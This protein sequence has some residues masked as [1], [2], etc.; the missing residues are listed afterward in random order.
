MNY[1][2]QGIPFK[3]LLNIFNFGRYG[4]IDPFGEVKEYTYQ[5]GIE[6]DPQTKQPLQQESRT[7]KGRKRGYFDYNSNRYVTRDGRKG[8]LTVNKN[9]RRR[10]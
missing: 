5:S 7:P 10:G 1:A 2:S 8:K 6:C 4:Y 3:S 9:N